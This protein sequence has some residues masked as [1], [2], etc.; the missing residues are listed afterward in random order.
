M[1]VCV[2]IARSQVDLPAPSE[3]Y[4]R[5]AQRGGGGVRDVD[6]QNVST[7]G[8]CGVATSVELMSLQ[9]VLWEGGGTCAWQFV[10][11]R[12]C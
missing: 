1:L 4:R 11:G 7:R 8:S 5:G 12:Y 6:K 10:P 2:W 3:A 9:K